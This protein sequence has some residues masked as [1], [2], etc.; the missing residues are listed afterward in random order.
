MLRFP[1]CF[2]LAV[3]LSQARAADRPNILWV[4]SEDNGPHLGCYGEPLAV[5]PNL[6][7]FAL[8]G[9]RYTHAS[10]NAP[11]CAPARTTVITGLYP[12]SVGAEHMR[13]EVRLPDGFKLF[14]QYLREAG[15]YCTN[16]SKEDYNLA[17]TGQIWDESSNK[18]HW[19]NRP[20]GQPFFAVFNTTISHESQIRNAIP[21]ENRIHD[22]AK[23]RIP[24][25]HPDTPETRRDWAQYHDRITMMDADCGRK[26]DE[27]ADAGLEGDTIV[28]YWGDHGSGMPRSKRWPYH[29]GLN[30]PLIVSFPE[31]WQHLAPGDYAAGGTSGRL[32]AFVDLAPTMLSLAGIEPPAWMQ[33]QA[34]A[35][36][37][38]TAPPEFSFGFRG[39]M[40]ERYDC[41]RTVMGP[42]YIYLRHYMPHKI[43]GQYIDYMFQTTTTRVW[44]D[45]FQAGKLNEAQ[46]LFWRTKPAEE[47]YD[48]ESDPDEVRNLAASPE[49]A[50]ILAAMRGAHG[51]HLRQIRDL[52]LLPEQ[53]VHAR[54]MAAGKTSYEMG[55]DPALYDFDVIFAAAELATAPRE[56][57]LPSVLALLDGGDSAVRY[58]G[59]TGILVRGREAVEASRDRLK[60]ALAD[61]APLVRIG[62]AEA[63]GRFGGD[64]TLPEVLDLLL[65]HLD[66][67]GDTLV[68]LEAWNAL[69]ALDDRARPALERIRETSPLPANP[70]NGRV[71]KYSA[72]VKKKII[73]DFGVPTDAR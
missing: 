26:L 39:R 11:V 56:G 16:N 51:D 54:S 40:D 57:D 9:M 23:V 21:E 60:L 6:D 15:Y 45:L 70:P 32:V 3:A 73:A 69:D 17:R 41:V 22:P 20:E 55:H 27:L 4:T 59:V 1:L 37:H 48:L 68:A 18:A 31:K 7:R 66:P 53:E 13:S 28:F 24:A 19:K 38:E 43:Y 12:P 36:P 35:G 44:H 52:G 30:V 33:G 72:N 29:S 58:W 47:L 34:F 64:D 5:T 61:E 46:S 50:G 49:H 2:I 8:R 62:A 63:L 10:S 71:A 14:P 25:Y 65:A 42:R 67:A